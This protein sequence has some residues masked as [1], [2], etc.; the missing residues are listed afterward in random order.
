M[1]QHTTKIAILDQVKKR[2][3]VL[4]KDGLVDVGKLTS[5]MLPL[6]FAFGHVITLRSYF[7]VGRYITFMCQSCCVA[8]AVLLYE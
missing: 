7:T 6:S 2:T 1:C 8:D 5:D 3:F 4:R